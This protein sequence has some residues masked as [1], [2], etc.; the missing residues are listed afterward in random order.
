[1]LAPTSVYKRM[2]QVMPI[3]FGSG[4]HFW[5]GEEPM[6]ML[7]SRRIRRWLRDRRYSIKDGYLFDLRDRYF[8]RYKTTAVGDEFD[9][10]W[11]SVSHRIGQ[12]WH[13]EGR[14]F[15]ER[16]WARTCEALIDG[17]VV[18]LR[19]AACVLAYLAAEVDEE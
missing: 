4:E 7:G 19:D 2:R 9:A 16:T 15:F 8:R 14:K 13:V 17:E 11:E 5:P 12:R 18:E 10:V 6:P 3:T 1:M